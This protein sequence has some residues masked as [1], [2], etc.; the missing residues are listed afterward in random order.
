MYP[1]QHKREASVIAASL[2]CL[3]AFPLCAADGG[4]PYFHGAAPM[5]GEGIERRVVDTRASA[6]CL[7]L[8]MR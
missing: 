6:M 4:R 8:V 2:G 5:I 3:D 1:D 7:D